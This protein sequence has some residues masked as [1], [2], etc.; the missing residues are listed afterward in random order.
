MKGMKK[1]KISLSMYY[2]ST[3][4]TVPTKNQLKL[5]QRKF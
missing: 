2:E 1:Y 3:S 4:E 5:C